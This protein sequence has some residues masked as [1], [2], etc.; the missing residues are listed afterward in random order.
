M[1]PA[2]R[3]RQLP[4]DKLGIFARLLGRLQIAYEA[5]AE[6]EAKGEDQAKVPTNEKKDSLLPGN[7]R[8]CKDQLGQPRCQE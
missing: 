2:S 4:S 1:I 6:G 3:L 8:R 5:Q 7:Q